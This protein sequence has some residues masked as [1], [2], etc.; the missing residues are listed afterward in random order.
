MQNGTWFQNETWFR[1]ESITMRI[2]V[3]EKN[4]DRIVQVVCN[5]CGRALPVENGIVLE[6]YLHVDKAW[7]YFS[8]QDGE[9]IIFDLCENCTQKLI[10]QF[11]LPVYQKETGVYLE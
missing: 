3:K 11:R 1:E 9:E 7:G 8:N 10:K 2:T 4:R 6:D 5:C